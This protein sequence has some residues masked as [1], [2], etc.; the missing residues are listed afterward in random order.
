MNA[1]GGGTDE[2][3]AAVSQLEQ[4]RN[5]AVEVVMLD[6]EYLVRLPYQ[7]WRALVS[8]IDDAIEDGR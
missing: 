8:A 1:D 3:P 4:I 6:S 7:V 5:E 2:R